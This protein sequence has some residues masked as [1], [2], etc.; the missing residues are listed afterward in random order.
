MKVL[1]T[2]ATGYLGSYVARR[3]AAAGHRVL[4]L[5]RSE[6]AARAPEGCERI[7]GDMRVPASLRKALTGCD[8]VVHLAALVRMWMRDR[9]E[10]DRVN[11][12]ALDDLLQAATEAGVSRFVYTSTIVALGPTDGGV[13][14][15]DSFDPHRQTFCTD[16]ERTKWLAELRVREKIKAGFPA[17]VVYP[18]VIYGPGAPTSG[19]L[20][21][22]VMNGMVTGRLRTFLGR[23]DLRI[24]YAFTDDVAEGHLRALESGEAGRGYVLGG[25]N[26]TQDE[27][28]GILADITGNPAP[29]WS[30]PYSV[31]GAVGAM[32]QG[33]AWMTGL[34]PAVTRGVVRTFRHE[35]AYRSDRAVREIG[36]RITSLREGLQRTISSIRELPEG[37]QSMTPPQ[38]G[39]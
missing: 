24:C 19:N 34:Q 23:G 12:T 4:A 20:L 39:G 21:R 32:A 10:F 25:E 2:G 36:Y 31:A 1:V 30:I 37:G 28:F 3:I 6:S 15:E 9:T 18:G 27:L 16:Y 26:A 35:W 14:D 11:V 7:Q 38:S 8:A 33:F 22:G 29:R 13:G 5:C 17:V